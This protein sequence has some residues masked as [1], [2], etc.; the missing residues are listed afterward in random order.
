MTFIFLNR[1][2]AIEAR[3]LGVLD[4]F[5]MIDPQLLNETCA[6]KSGESLKYLIERIMEARKDK[7]VFVPH[8]SHGHWVLYVYN[9]D[10]NTVYVFDSLPLQDNVQFYSMRKD[11]H[12]M[13]DRYVILLYLL[14]YFNKLY[15]NF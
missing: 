15:R 2:L 4:M 6:V 9:P 10:R 7:L 11:G 3:M 12:D 8:L 1:Y 13:M 5:Q 14:F